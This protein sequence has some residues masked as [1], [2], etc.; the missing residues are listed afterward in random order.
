MQALLLSSWSVILF[1]SMSFAVIN[2]QDPV[3]K[4][5]GR[6][7]MEDAGT[8]GMGLQKL[9]NELRRSQGYSGICPRGVYRF[10]SHQEADAWMM[11]AIV[12]RAVRARN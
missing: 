3:G 9:V 5:V 2:I 11:K 8:Y 4:T 6:R 12:E 10:R 7:V 1:S